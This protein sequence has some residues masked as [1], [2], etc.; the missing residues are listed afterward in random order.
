MPLGGKERDCSAS[1]T[2]KAILTRALNYW[3]AKCRNTDKESHPIHPPQFPS[4][5]NAASANGGMLSGM[6]FVSETAL[7]GRD[8]VLTSS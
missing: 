8:Q 2:D 4:T 6:R 5:K 1:A 3:P 7:I